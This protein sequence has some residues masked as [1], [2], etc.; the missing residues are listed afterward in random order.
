MTRTEVL[1]D[2]QI[3]AQALG[4]PLAWTW[5]VAILHAVAWGGK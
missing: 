4:F 1:L 3:E 2:S 5:I